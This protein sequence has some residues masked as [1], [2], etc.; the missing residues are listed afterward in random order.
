MPKPRLLLHVC[1]G[2]CSSYVPERLLPDF[3]VT[4]YYENSNLYP[5][6]EFGRRRDAAKTMADRYGV[7][8]LEAPYEPIA[9]T[10]SVAGMAQEPERGLRCT[11]CIRFRL[12]RTFAFA[13]ENGFGW[14]ATTLSVSRRKDVATINAIGDGLAD[15]HGVEFLGRD[16]KKGNGEVISQERAKAAGIYRQDYCGC[17]YSFVLRRQRD[18]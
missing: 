12:D 5:S 10:R 18:G 7:T 9:W 1:C 2:V 4:V 17:V 11:S 13:K 3:D 8:F 16:W 15:L 14:V 6:S